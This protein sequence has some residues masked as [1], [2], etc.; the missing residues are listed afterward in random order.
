MVPEAEKQGPG[1]QQSRD[2][3]DEKNLDHGGATSRGSE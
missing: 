1:S 3:N 2:R